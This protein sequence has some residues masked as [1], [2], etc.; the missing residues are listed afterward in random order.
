MSTVINFFDENRE[1]LYYVGRITA[2]LVIGPILIFKGVTYRDYLILSIGILLILWDG[3][4][5]GV[6]LM[7][8]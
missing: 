8:E 1:T 4:K 6:Q 7:K 5:I 3:M 2:V